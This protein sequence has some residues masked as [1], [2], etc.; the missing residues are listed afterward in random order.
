MVRQPYAKRRVI[1]KYALL[2]SLLH[3]QLV[4]GLQMNLEG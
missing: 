2:K 3:H 4:H 1:Q